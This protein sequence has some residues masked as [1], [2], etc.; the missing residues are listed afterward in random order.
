MSEKKERI[1][2]LQRSDISNQNDLLE[3][4]TSSNLSKSITSKTI[5][6]G[7]LGSFTYSNSISPN[8]SIFTILSN[9]VLNSASAY[10]NQTT[11]NVGH[12]CTYQSKLYKCIV[13]IDS[14][15]DFNINHWLR[16]SVSEVVNQIINRINAVNDRIDWSLKDIADEYDSTSTYVEGDYAIHEDKL[17]M[18]NQD[19]SVPEDFDDTKWDI[20]NIV[21]NLSE[22]VVYTAGTNI[23]ISAQNVISATDTTYTAGDGIS[24]SNQNVIS[25]DV[26]KDIA[27]EYDSS[28]TY[29]IGDYTWMNE[30]PE[31]ASNDAFVKGLYKKINEPSNSGSAEGWYQCTQTFDL[32]GGATQAYKSKNGLD[33]YLCYIKNGSSNVF[34]ITSE[35][36][37]A[38][39][40]V[41]MSGTPVKNNL[42]L[43]ST[44]TNPVGDTYCYQ[45]FPT[46]NISPMA[47]QESGTLT[48]VETSTNDAL[49][50]LWTPPVQEWEKTDVG[51]ELK[52]LKSSMIS[53]TDLTGTLTAG[54]T[55]LTISDAS[56]TTSSTIDYYTDVYGVNPTDATVVNGSITL[57]FDAQS[58]DLHV[59]VRVW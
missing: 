16:T 38:Q 17:Y 19:I 57:T 47:S 26:I 12:L 6:E 41:S 31:N 55:S 28:S 24:I 32:S 53:F 59:K 56:I 23:S 46:P 21:S 33:T 36:S 10:S 14:P 27:E 37:V 9:L 1:S 54:S 48:L 44:Y 20:T 58:S 49:A 30:D 13:A 51:I 35:D 7:I 18:A 22:G 52:T 42:S 25:N 4:C 43:D 2:D 3:I 34:L 45:L 11:Y 8:E 50:A 40:E 39:V 5:G 15:E 29:A